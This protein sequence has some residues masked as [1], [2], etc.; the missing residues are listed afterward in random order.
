MAAALVKMARAIQLFRVMVFLSC[1]SE[2][3]HREKET[4]L[5][6]V[7]VLPA[8]FH[9]LGGAEINPSS[10]AEPECAQLTNRPPL[11]SSSSALERE[12]EWLPMS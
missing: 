8:S 5:A 7:T 3:Q 12:G 2:L 10:D 11:M 4:P 6:E 9:S 1:L